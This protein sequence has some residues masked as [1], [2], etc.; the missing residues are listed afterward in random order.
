M[1]AAVH[2]AVEDLEAAIRI[3]ASRLT[4]QEALELTLRLLALRRAAGMPAKL[5]GAS[6]RLPRLRVVRPPE[7]P[8]AA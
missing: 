5:A 1:S 7:G 4:T 6:G 3:A 8:E 2:T